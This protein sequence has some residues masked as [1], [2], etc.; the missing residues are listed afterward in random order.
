MKKQAIEMSSEQKVMQKKHAKKAPK[1]TPKT[2]NVKKLKLDKEIV[3]YKKTGDKNA[4]PSS[5]YTIFP[6][7]TYS[8][9]TG[10]DN[11]KVEKVEETLCI[12]TDPIQMK[13]G[14]ILKVDPQYRPTD[15]DCTALWIPLD[16]K[17]GGEGAIEL[18][19]MLTSIDDEFTEK[20][21]E[22]GYFNVKD[23]GVLKHM[24][25]IPI[26]RQAEKPPGAG[27]DFV[28]WNRTKVRIPFKEVATPDGNRKEIDVKLVVPGDDGEPVKKVATSIAELRKDFTYGCTAQFFLEVKTFWILRTAKKSGKTSKH[29]CGFKVTCKMINITEKSKTSSKED[30]DWENILDDDDDDIVKPVQQV[31]KLEKVEKKVEKEEKEEKKEKKNDSSSEDDSDSSEEEVKPK[32]NAK[33]IDESSSSSEESE[34][35]EESEVKK[36]KNA[37]KGKSKSK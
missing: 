27:D 2:F 33:K 37:K 26:V 9:T 6:K 5:Q 36:G 14:G 10:D 1:V 17:F 12:L 13:R 28:E 8:Q 3:E 18:H 35:E 20:L 22:E 24:S 19:N 21:E 29:D 34:D 15:D 23:G 16:E 32:K 11:E 7:Y 31:K 4:K 25:Y 30:Y